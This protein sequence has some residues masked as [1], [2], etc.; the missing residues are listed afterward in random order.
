MYFNSKLSS[1]LLL[2]AISLTPIA[3]FNNIDNIEYKNNTPYTNNISYPD[4]IFDNALP[5]DFFGDYSH[6]EFWTDSHKA[7]SITRHLIW[8]FD[9]KL[10]YREH[11]DAYP[12]VGILS[13]T[14]HTK[15]YNQAVLKKHYNH[16][17]SDYMPWL[18]ANPNGF[19]FIDTKKI[20]LKVFA[21]YIEDWIVWNW[22]T[23]LHKTSKKHI[24]NDDVDLNTKY[25]CKLPKWNSSRI[26]NI[27]ENLLLKD[28][29]IKAG[30]NFSYLWDSDKK[31][32]YSM[33][34]L[35]M[36]FNNHNLPNQAPWQ[37]IIYWNKG[38]ELWR[39]IDVNSVT[40]L[41]LPQWRN[42]ITKHINNKQLSIWFNQ[43]GKI[44]H[45]SN[46]DY[47]PVYKESFSSFLNGYY[48]NTNSNDV[49]NEQAYQ[50]G[51]KDEINKI[52]NKDFIHYYKDR[53]SL[54]PLRPKA[55]I[56][57]D[58]DQGFYGD[59]NPFKKTDYNIDY[60]YKLNNSWIPILENSGKKLYSLNLI[61]I[62]ITSPENARTIGGKSQV[63][64]IILDTKILPHD[65][66]N[67]IHNDTNKLKIIFIVLGIFIGVAIILISIY[68]AKKFNI[69]RI[70]KDRNKKV[71]S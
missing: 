3:T 71:H 33:Y 58:D 64:N 53:E 24:T 26:K 60:F 6:P 57:D 66:N 40:R 48:Y 37:K 20:K 2:T 28:S 67:H 61:K 7:S 5:Y 12:G 55:W 13:W 49:K 42:D 36:N 15:D 39:D 50:I 45:W 29:A 35:E 65:G 69:I 31:F 10:P 51:L 68:M 22:N 23:H 19:R 52:L 41:F 38:E 47:M 4:P 11:H 44:K 14:K 32:G 62:K 46:Y 1:V 34:A 59:S 17:W 8:K 63:V 21:E 9:A 30:L 16:H 18:E 25:L 27:D 56:D 43:M 54:Q 70:K